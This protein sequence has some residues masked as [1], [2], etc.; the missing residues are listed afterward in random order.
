MRVSLLRLR[1]VSQQPI[2]EPLTASFQGGR[3]VGLIGPNGAGKSTLLK[4]IVGLLPATGGD[5]QVDGISLKK[6][7]P[8]QRARF[9]SYLPQSIA[10]DIPYTVA[11]FVQMGRYSRAPIWASRTTHHRLAVKDALAL[12][13]LTALAEVPL[14]HISG[15]E[16]QRAGIAR[17]LAQESPVL[18]LD[19]PISNL[20][21]FYQLDILTELRKLA[22]AG[23]LIVIAIHHLEFALRFCDEVVVLKDGRLYTH[24]SVESVFTRDMLAEVFRVNAQLFVDPTHHHPRLSLAPL[25]ANDSTNTGK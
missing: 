9:I 18:L 5:V 8:R 7:S 3:V 21:V 11:E 13:G 1:D 20:D 24:G 14:Q 10:E 6:L 19:E 4:T 2:L 22:A 15:G 17:C 16:R 12:M 25:G 23:Y